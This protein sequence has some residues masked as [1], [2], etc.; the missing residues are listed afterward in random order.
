MPISSPALGGGGDL[1]IEVMK[2]HDI[3]KYPSPPPPEAGE[4]MG[5]CGYRDIS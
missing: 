1:K 5:I 3:H 2:Y 4:E